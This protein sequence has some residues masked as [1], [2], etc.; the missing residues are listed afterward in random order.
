[1]AKHDIQMVALPPGRIF[2][3]IPPI[4]DA[5]GLRTQGIYSIPFECGRVYIGQSGGSI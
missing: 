5:F 2:S 3:Y 4:K 1:M